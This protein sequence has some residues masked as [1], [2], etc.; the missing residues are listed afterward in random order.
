[1]P[2]HFRVFPKANKTAA[3]SH[4]EE[5]QGA[6]QDTPTLCQKGPKASLG[7]EAEVSSG[8]EAETLSKENQHR[9]QEG[10]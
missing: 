9:G 2:T 1:M 5:A 10:L 3:R 7:L 6:N 8:E 4:S